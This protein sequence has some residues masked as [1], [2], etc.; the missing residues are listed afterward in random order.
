MYQELF[1]SLSVIA[2]VFTIYKGATYVHDYRYKM[3]INLYD[4]P[5]DKFPTLFPYDEILPESFFE[6][7]AFYKIGDKINSSDEEF[8]PVFFKNIP[9]EVNHLPFVVIFDPILTFGLTDREDLSL[10]K[11][12]FYINDKKVFNSEQ[13]KGCIV[14]YWAVKKSNHGQILYS[15]DFW[16]SPDECTK[17]ERLMA[18]DNHII[19]RYAYNGYFNT[20]YNLLDSDD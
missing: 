12:S 14:A 9:F 19:F 4:S 13:L 3:S 16:I 1:I 6:I 5:P 2:F 17:E 7:E 20:F 18:K 8:I 11:F 15:K 10:V